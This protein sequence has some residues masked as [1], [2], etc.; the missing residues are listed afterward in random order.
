MFVGE[1][2]VSDSTCRRTS[3][4]VVVDERQRR[5]YHAAC[6]E[7]LL[8]GPLINKGARPPALL[9]VIVQ[10]H[11]ILRKCLAGKDRAGEIEICNGPGRV[12]AEPAQIG[13][14]L[15]DLRL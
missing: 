9:E 7:P 4:R 12:R 11:L 6:T 10:H 14:D 3:V 2:E 15:A 13:D 5:L 1:R 8:Q